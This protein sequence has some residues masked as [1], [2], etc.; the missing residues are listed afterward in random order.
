MIP[1]R[2]KNWA[3]ERAYSTRRF[4]NKGVAM[5]MLILTGVLVGA[6]LGLRFKMLVLVP[7]LCGALAFIVIGGIAGGDTLWRL[8]FTMIVFATVLQ[9]G[10]FLGNVIRLVTGAARASDHRASMP[11]TAGMSRTV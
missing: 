5:I 7:V 9:M 2:G 6:V 3:R 1:A 8:A 10:Y 11:T 4:S